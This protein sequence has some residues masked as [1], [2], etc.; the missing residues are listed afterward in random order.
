MSYEITPDM[1]ETNYE[2]CHSCRYGWGSYGEA[3]CQYILITDEK[4]ECPVGWC[5]K[6]EPL[7]GRKGVIPP[8][9]Y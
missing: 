6:Y 8:E 5:N 3:F 4:R 7:V 2:M 9:W 1:R